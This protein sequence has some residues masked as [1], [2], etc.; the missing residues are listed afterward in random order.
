M[1]NNSPFRITLRVASYCTL[2]SM[3]I[4]SYLFVTSDNT[5]QF[6]LTAIVSVLLLLLSLAIGFYFGMRRYYEKQNS[7][8][9]EPALG[10]TMNMPAVHY[11]ARE[12]FNRQMDAVDARVSRLYNKD[13]RYA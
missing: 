3:A 5:A 6:V 2:A 11:P 8:K 13:G 9:V 1:K 7:F 12:M 4:S 10:S